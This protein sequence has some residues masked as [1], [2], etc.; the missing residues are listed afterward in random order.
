METRDMTMFW[1]AGFMLAVR[2]EKF[3][4]VAVFFRV[5]PCL[6]RASIDVR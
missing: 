5:W 2:V 3:V 6:A 1:M 4:D